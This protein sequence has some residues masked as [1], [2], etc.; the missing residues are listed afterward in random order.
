MNYG[1]YLHHGGWDNTVG[2]GQ[3]YFAGQEAGAESGFGVDNMGY[4]SSL[5]AMSCMDSYG[6]FGDYGAS[7]GYEGDYG[8]SSGDSGG[9]AGGYGGGDGGGYGGEY[10]G[11]GGS[12]CSE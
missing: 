2:P 11:D 3:S 4:N 9:Y 12:G 10:G 1:N 8:G 6:G 5:D 7:A